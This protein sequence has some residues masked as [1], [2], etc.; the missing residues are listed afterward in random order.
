MFNHLRRGALFIRSRVANADSKNEAVRIKWKRKPKIEL[1]T[2]RA[3]S[4]RQVKKSTA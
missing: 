3:A 2:R 1:P 4:L